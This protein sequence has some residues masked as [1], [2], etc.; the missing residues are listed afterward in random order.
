MARPN[1]SAARTRRTSMSRIQIADP[2]SAIL[3]KAT[4][5]DID[6]PKVGLLGTIDRKAA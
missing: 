3:G 1:G 5:V 4:R 2:K 6:F